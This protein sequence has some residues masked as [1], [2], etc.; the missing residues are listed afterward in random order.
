MGLTVQKVA[1][2]EDEAAARM[3]MK[4]S[5]SQR[6]MLQMLWVIVAI[7]A[8][9]FQFVAGILP[10]LFPGTGIKLVGIIGRKK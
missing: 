10:L 4:A 1:A 7:V 6:M 2:A 9:C 5:Y 3:K 8:P